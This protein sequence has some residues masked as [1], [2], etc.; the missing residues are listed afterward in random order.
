MASWEP[1]N[2][3][4]GAPDG[5][6]AQVMSLR[7]LVVE[8]DADAAEAMA[9]LLTMEGCKVHVAADGPAALQEAEA[10]H[11]EVVLLDLG[12]PG[13]NGYD[14]ARGLRSQKAERRPLLIAVTGYGEHADRVRSY[15]SGIDLHL[16]KPV[17]IDELRQFLSRFQTVSVPPPVA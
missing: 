13:M 16:T 2:G 11:P 10:N 14:V 7:V 3:H 6:G 8:D 15:E 1:V 5:P 17:D 4:R 12:L 9:R